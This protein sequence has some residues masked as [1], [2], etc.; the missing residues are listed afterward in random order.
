[1][2]IDHQAIEATRERIK[3]EHLRAHR[4]PSSARGLHHFALISSDVETTIAFYQD[5]LEFPLTEIFEN[6]DYRG[7]NHFFFDIGNGNLLAFFDFPGL[8][9][10]PYK[11]VL[12]GLHHVAIS[13]DPPPGSACGA[14]WRRRAFLTRSRAARP[15]TSPT[16]TG[17]AWSCSPTPSERCTAPASSDG[18]SSPS[19][20]P[21]FLVPGRPT[22]GR[23]VPSPAR[24]LLPAPPPAPSFPLTPSPVR[25]VRRGRESGDA[26]GPAARGPAAR[27]AG[28]G[29]P[30]WIHTWGMRLSDF[31]KRMKSHFGDQ[32]AESWAR[33]YVI[34]DLGSRT[35]I[36][37]LADG[38]GAKEVWHAVCGVTD[39]A[40][41]LR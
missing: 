1:M 20:P 14:S 13:V 39:V 11:E 10:G 6:R 24:P 9:L 28:R 30:E 3:A 16:P 2:S 38:V 25:P 26:G 21:P 12:G 8:D 22:L 7:S 18:P 4:P 36:Q 27:R 40:P 15:S 41:R 33:D 23:D 5:L 32:Y 31:W 37:A 29:A 34:A 19:P 35:V 17:P